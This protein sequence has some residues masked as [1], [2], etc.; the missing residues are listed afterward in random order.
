MNATKKFLSVDSLKPGM[1]TAEA[2]FNR[3]GSVLLWR[4]LFLT[5]A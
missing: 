1:V 4:I 5:T 2:V 3:F